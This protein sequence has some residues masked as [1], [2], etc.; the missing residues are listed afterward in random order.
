MVSRVTVVVLVAS[1]ALAACQ[2]FQYSRGVKFP[3][4]DIEERLRAVEAGVSALLRAAQQNPE[5][6]AAAVAGEQDY[7]AQN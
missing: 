1:L 6:A 5:A 3:T 4:Q 7:Y 2:T